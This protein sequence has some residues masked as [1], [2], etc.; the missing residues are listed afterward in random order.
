MQYFDAVRVVLVVALFA[1]ARQSDA[2]TFDTIA[3]SGATGTELGYG[4]G[5][6]PGVDFGQ[7]NFTSPQLNAAG[8]VAFIAPTT[9]S[10]GMWLSADGVMTPIAREGPYEPGPNVEAGAMFNSMG[11]LG[12]I[13]LNA[14][15]QA[16]LKGFLTGG[17]GGGIWTNVGGTLAAAAR[18]GNRLPGPNLGSGINF[19]T[20]SNLPQIND[21]GE[22]LFTRF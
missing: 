18:D 6:G 4:P 20:V 3:L 19:S 7:F 21:A 8:D 17:S 16:A 15:G 13:G 9:Q 1:A 14:S 2:A 11:Q 22:L 12:G 5:L 10:V